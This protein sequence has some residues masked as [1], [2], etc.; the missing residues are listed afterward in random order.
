VLGA[1]GE[2]VLLR[3]VAQDQPLEASNYLQ[4]VA[5]QLRQS[6]LDLHVTCDVRTGD[7]A[8]AIAAAQIDRG[9]DL[10]T[11]PERGMGLPVDTGAEVG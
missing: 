3:V 5:N 7:A 9:V 8:H 1:A 4:Q 6:N 2:L 10:G 11:R